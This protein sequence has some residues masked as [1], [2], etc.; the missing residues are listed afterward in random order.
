MQ[1]QATSADRLREI[2]EQ[3][4]EGVRKLTTSEDWQQA[5]AFAARFHS[6]SFGNVLLIRR[7]RPEAS[8]VAGFHRWLELGRHVRKGEHGIAILAPIVARKHDAETTDD[9]PERV[10]RFFRPAS[11]VDVGQTDGAEL[12]R[13]VFAE[14]LS[15]GSE[16][17]SELFA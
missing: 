7:Q 15:G 11:V 10:V 17:E 6:Y 16:R 13:T 9:E 3:L 2:H 1:E 12:P 14:R 4:Q 5:L 8:Y